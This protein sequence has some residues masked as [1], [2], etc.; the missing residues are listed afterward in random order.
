MAV[1][2]GK[3]TFVVPFAVEGEKEV[4]ENALGVVRDDLISGAKF[5]KR[6]KA[7]GVKVFIDEVV[8]K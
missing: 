7:E 5:P 8:V 3:V 6:L 4:L 1:K 2:K